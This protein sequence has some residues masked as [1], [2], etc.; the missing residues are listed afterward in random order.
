MASKLPF[1]NT[2]TLFLDRDGVINKKLENDYVKSVSEFEYID[3]SL[4]ATVY[5]SLFF[6]NTFVVT[7]QQGIGKGLMLEQDVAVI[8][9]KLKNDVEALGG[10]LTEIYLAP[11]LAEENSPMRKPNIGMAEMANIEYPEVDIKK[12]VMVGDSLTDMEFADNAGMY[13]VF[14]GKDPDKIEAA[15]AGLNF[16]D[17]A[18]FWNFLADEFA[19]LFDE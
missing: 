11:E 18:D 9:Q 5:L 13:K 19:Y 7:N 10:K 3:N 4:I 8:H 1:D 15:N 2:W 12:G 14:I 17:L 6:T 16:P